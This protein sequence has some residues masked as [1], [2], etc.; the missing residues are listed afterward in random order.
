M[1]LETIDH[2]RPKSSFPHRVYEWSN[3]FFCCDRCQAAKR[4]DFSELLLKP[5]EAEYEFSRY[6][7]VNY[8]SGEIQV[9]PLAATEEQAKATF[10]IEL[11][12]LNVNV[13]CVS[14]QRELRHSKLEYDINDCCY[15]YLFEWNIKIVSSK[16]PKPPPL[17][18]LENRIELKKRLYAQCVEY[19]AQR[20]ATARLAMEAAQRAANEESKSSAGD[21]YETTRAM[22]Q[23]ERDRHAAQL[24][25]ALKLQQELTQLNCEKIY[26]KAQPGSVV[27]TDQNRFFLAISAGKLTIDQ[28]DYFAVSL[29]S[30]VGKLLH[31]RTAGEEFMFQNKV[32]RITDVFWYGVTAK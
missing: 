10:T 18:S 24:A 15:R 4:E 8:D 3:L 11:L 7:I 23:L 9:N 31:N 21:K 6:F 17:F 29:A 20:I 27:A 2:F 16:T 1:S 28:T 5:D 32:M 22:M 13:I 12:N 14:R 30:P 25:E 19:V 26:E